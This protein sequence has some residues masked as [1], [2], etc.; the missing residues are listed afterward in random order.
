MVKTA[1]APRHG[2][3]LA[4]VAVLVLVAVLVTVSVAAASGASVADAAAAV[5]AA[6]TVPPLSTSA[7]P[8]ACRIA[9]FTTKYKRTTEWSRTLLDWRLRLPSGYRPTDLVPV[10]RAGLAGGGYV[11]AIALPDLRAMAS[12]A[13]AAGAPLAV[14]SAYRSY[15]NQISTF[16]YW[17]GLFGYTHA[18][19]GSARPGHSEHELGT[20]L[21]F[22]SYGGGVPWSYGGFDWA[23]TKAGAW[24]ARYAWR[25]GFVMSYPRGK[26]TTVCYGYEP[27]HYRYF[28]RTIAAAMHASGLTTR[29][30]L[31]RHGNNPGW[32][33]PTPTPSPSNSPTPSP[34][35]TT[36]P[37]PT[38]TTAP[39]PT[40]TP[41]PTIPTP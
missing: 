13:R 7:N 18:I 39:T 41:T 24:M 6:P 14:Q 30:W 35:D 8:P 2:L 25:Y 21:D 37:T 28:G 17:V 5:L 20:A 36:A 9:D 22:K 23:K 33:D 1:R 10:S 4:A 40:P 3:R 31:W 26:Q 12:S 32:V 38:D 16:S 19:I 15:S 29:T 34:T 27:W 11:R